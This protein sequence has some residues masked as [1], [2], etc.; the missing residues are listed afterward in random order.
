MNVR[1]LW[2]KP[3]SDVQLSFG[4]LQTLI[5]Y[6]IVLR[7]EW[8]LLWNELKPNFPD[9]AGFVPAIA[10]AVSGWCNALE[11]I[12][13]DDQ[14]EAWTEELLERVGKSNAVKVVLEVCLR[15]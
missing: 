9:N 12:A 4:K 7:P 8:D 13:G 10:S 6:E 2:D 5:G 1:D 14:N 11:E 15:K 3:D